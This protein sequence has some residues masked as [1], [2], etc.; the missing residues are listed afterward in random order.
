MMESLYQEKERA[1][2]FDSQIYECFMFIVFF[3]LTV[4]EVGYKSLTE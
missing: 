4:I 2:D 1:C 3:F